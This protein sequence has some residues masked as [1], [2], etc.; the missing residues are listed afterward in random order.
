MTPAQGKVYW[1]TGLSGSGKSTLCTTL[2]A[3]LRA[4]GEPVVMLDGDELRA[5]LGGGG[6]HS[7][8]NRLE[9]AQAYGRLCQLLAS[10]GVTVAIATISMFAEVHAWNREHLPGYCEIFLDVPLEELTRRDPKSIYRRAA[11]GE[12]R[13]VAGVD[14]AVD[15]PLKPHVHVPWDPTRDARATFE[16]VW[17][18]L[19]RSQTSV[20]RVADG[21]H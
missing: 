15:R 21:R 20:A 14:F 6:G 11:T 8:E 17:A 19:G 2:V 4:A 13:N 3:A 7:R 9:L 18:T 16:L 5:V 12:L 1:I 10:Q